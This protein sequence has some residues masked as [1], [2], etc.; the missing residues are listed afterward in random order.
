MVLMN[1]DPAGL[2]QHVVDALDPWFEVSYMVPSDV[3]LA[4]A[5]LDTDVFVTSGGRTVF[6]AAALGVPTVVIPQHER[7]SGHGHLGDGRNIV[8]DLE[9]VLDA[10]TTLMT[11]RALRV[12][13]SAKARVDGYGGQRIVAACEWLMNGY[14]GKYLSPR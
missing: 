2:L 12:R 7:E 5:M 13:M 1:S 10:V 3:P 11:D 14:G 9:G 8:T 6:E 4:T